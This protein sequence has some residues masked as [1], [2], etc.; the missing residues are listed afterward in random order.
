[1]PPIANH[2]VRDFNGPRPRITVLCGSS[3]FYDEYQQA[4]Y[5]LTM[6]GRIVLSVGFYPHALA[7]HGHGEGV[8]H[9]SAEKVKLDELHL[10][11]IDLADDVFVINPGGY[12]GTSTRREITYAFEHRKPVR[13]LEKMCDNSSVGA[14]CEQEGKLLVIERADGAG[15]APPAGH[16]T[17]HGGSLRE[18]VC[19]EVQ[20]ETGLNADLALP[21]E[22][23]SQWRLNRCKRHEGLDGLGHF[24]HYFQVA[25]SGTIDPDPTETKKVWWATRE[26]LAELADR[27][28][29]YARGEVTAEE[30]AA[31]PGIEPVWMLPLADRAWIPDVDVDDLDRIEHVL[32]T[33]SNRPE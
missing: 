14:I 5:D 25:V 10:R 30:F 12:I 4:Y 32:Q 11:K 33:G 28:V 16:G 6:Q 15:V 3:R 26:E 31:A 13:W 22:R 19:Q 23:M 21:V 7:E 18:A 17:E 9:D 8:G 27:T 29:A 2:L 1:M 24:W 20:E